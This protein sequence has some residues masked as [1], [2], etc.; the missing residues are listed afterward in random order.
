M[1]IVATIFCLPYE[2]DE[3]EVLLHQLRSASYHL[4][5]KVELVLDVTLCLS[6]TMVNWSKS[7]IHKKYFEDKFLTISSQTDWCIKYFKTT[8]DILGSTSHR[9]D[10]FN[11][12]H[13]SADHFI[14]IDTRIVF[15]EKT[16][17]YLE[18][19]LNT[20]SPTNPYSIVTP[21]LVR[22]WDSSWDIIVNENFRH[23]EHN[24]QQS[25][26][27]YKDSG[28]Y[29]EVVTQ[30]VENKLEG[31]PRYKFMAGIFTCISTPLLERIGIPTSF[32]NFG[33]LDTFIMCSSEKLTQT[34]DI[35]VQQ[36]K[37]KNV[38]VLENYKYSN[39]F[40]Y[41]NNMTAADRKDEFEKIAEPNFRKELD[42]IK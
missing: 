6:A 5:N 11:T 16:L 23:K 29:G 4:S 15:P 13:E 3:L 1:R 20:I 33:Y 38:V 19:S 25:A 42:N 9:R 17:Y 41:L 24:Y 31:Q 32:G 36:F 22:M 37:M 30:K 7:S 21:E 40:H 28:I 27:P 18:Q 34:T 10:S 2:I 12:H 8:T 26:N 39:Y 35:H 14:W